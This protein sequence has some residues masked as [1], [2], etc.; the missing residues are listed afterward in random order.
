MPVKEKVINV[1]VNGKRNGYIIDTLTSVD[2]CE[3]VKTGGRVIEI[4]EGVIYRENFKISPFRKGIEKLFAPR[5]KYED[6]HNDLMQKLVK[7]IM[8]SLY[9]VQIRKDIDQTYKCKSQH[10]M[11][12][13]YD[14][15]VLDYWKLPDGSYIVKFKK[16]DGLEGGNDVKN[17]LPSH[18]GAFMLS[19]SK[20]NM[21]NFIREINAF[22]NSSKYYGDT[23]SVYIE[24]KFW[25]VLDKAKLVGENLCQGKNDYKTGGIF[26]ALFLAPKVKYCLTIN[27]L[28]I[29]E[30]HMFF[31]GFNGSKRL[32]DRSQYFDMLD[33]KKYQ[34]CFQDRGKTHLITALLYQQKRDNA[35]LLKIQK[36]VQHVIIKSMKI[37]NSKLI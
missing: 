12:T 13:E 19:N 11:E 30:Q 25:D 26:Y 14:E 20:R 21:N 27:E 10:W 36:Y 34:L 22:Y 5:Q 2:I 33:G 9:G 37:K 29:I 23:D 7:L 24:K 3:I 35:M 15:N 1:E 31:K 28:G 18:L 8:N 17:T 32:L 16:D 6:E 4:Y